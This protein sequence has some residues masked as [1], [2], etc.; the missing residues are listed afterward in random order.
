LLQAAVKAKIQ[1]F[2]NSSSSSVYGRVKNTPTREED[3]KSPIS[4]YGVTKLAA[5]NLVTLFGS[6]FGLNTI[7][8]R[9]FTVYGPGQR[10][11]MAFNKLIAAALSGS[12]FPLHGDGS[13]IRDFTFVGDVVSAN[14]LAGIQKTVPGSVFNVGGG[15]PVSMIE[16]ISLIEELMG[17]RIKTENVPFGPGNPTV[18][19]ANCLAIEE[20]LGWR[21][22]VDIH[23][24]LEA[25]INW[26]K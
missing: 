26:Q 8:L 2:I 7:S 24:G 5:E 12:A 15:S 17:V 22:N 11:D 10:P 9:Y 1:K 4:P 14:K 23:Q 18:T 19:T 16:A 13:Q 6:E 20:A 25:Q 3:A 21:S